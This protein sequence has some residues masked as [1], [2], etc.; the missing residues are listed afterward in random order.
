MPGTA[1]WGQG[2]L[3]ALFAAFVSDYLFIPPF[4]EISVG[5]KNLSRFGLFILV[6]VFVRILAIRQQE[7]EKSRRELAAIVESSDW[8]VGGTA[9]A[10]T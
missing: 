6:V 10:L 3:S 1:A 4:F 5:I 7:T 8:L 2:I 9:P